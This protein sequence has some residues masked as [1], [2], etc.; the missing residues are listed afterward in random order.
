MADQDV[1]RRDGGRT[2]QLVEFVGDA[3]SGSR[4]RARLAPAKTGAIV[5]ARAREA[6]DRGVHQT[7]A[8]RRAAK[9]RI[10]DYGRSAVA[11]TPDVQPVSTNAHQPSGSLR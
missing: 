4:Q 8:Q 7:P 9:R 5:A 2:K 10:E 6:G 11:I 1:W 3:A